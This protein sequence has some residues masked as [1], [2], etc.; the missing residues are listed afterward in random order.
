[1]ALPTNRTDATPQGPSTHAGDHNAVNQAVNDLVAQAASSVVTMTKA[2]GI[3]AT[4]LIGESIA[5]IPMQTI[6]AVPYKRLVEV[7]WMQL[8]GF[9]TASSTADLNIRSGSDNSLLARARIANTP[10]GPQNASGVVYYSAI[11]PANEN[12][13][14]YGTVTA[15][16]QQCGTFLDNYTNMMTIIT[17]QAP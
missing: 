14:V 10:G 16:T 12:A 3:A 13:Y 11:I 7:T 15:N 5:V 1:M 4:I 17:R 2:A 9:T 6:L 8:V